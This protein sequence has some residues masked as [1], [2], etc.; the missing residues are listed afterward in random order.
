LQ[1]NQHSKVLNIINIARRAQK[2]RYLRSSIYNAYA[3]LSTIKTLF[4]V[5]A[6]A[7]NL[8]ETAAKKLNLTNRSCLKVLRVARTIADLDSCKMV[9]AGHI[10]EALQ[11]RGDG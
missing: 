9:E 3:S 11:F 10:A 5:S 1:E 2:E 6:E 4:N 7:Q 8:V